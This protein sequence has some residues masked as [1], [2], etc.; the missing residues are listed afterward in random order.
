[1]NHF[2]IAAEH[3]SAEGQYY[4]G[5]IYYSKWLQITNDKVSTLHPEAYG[6]NK[7]F[8]KALHYFQL[9]SQGG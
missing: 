9:A 2:Q 1:M 6:V 8:K 3:G 5:L 7:D 4:M